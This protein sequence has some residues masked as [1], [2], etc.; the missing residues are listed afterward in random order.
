MFENPRLS[1]YAVSSR[2]GAII[3]PGI[4]T[5]AGEDDDG[6]ESAARVSEYREEDS[7]IVYVKLLFI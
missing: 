6:H 5:L 3:M 1:C 2:E 4:I 7:C